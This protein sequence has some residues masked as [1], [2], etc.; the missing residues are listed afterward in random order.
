MKNNVKPKVS[1]IVPVY[2]VEKY[3]EKCLVS[4]I[5]QTYKN[6]EF[7][8][9]NDGSKDNSCKII[10]DIKSKISDNRIKIISQENAGVSAARNRGLEEST[11]EY[12]VFVDADDFLAK[13][14][15]E[16]MVTLILKYDSDFA[17]SIENFKKRGEEQESELFD[18]M[19]TSNESVALLL[20]LRVTVGCWNKIYKKKLLV[21]NDIKFFTDLFYGEGLSFI[22]RVSQAT[23][24]IAI[25]NK[26]VY[27]YRKNNENSATTKYDNKKFHN[28][29]KALI[30]IGKSIDLSNEQIKSSYFIHLATFYLG[31]MVKII[32]NKKTK[33]MKLDY[34][35]WK[36]S[37]RNNMIYI[38]K[39]RYISLYRKLMI[40]GGIFFPHIIAILDVRRN[41]KI[42]SSSV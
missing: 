39:S 10:N 24:K 1:V 41:K 36:K 37:L 23:S 20:G 34:K 2:N 6:C 12:I 11:G 26:K 9:V 42:F 31:A 35:K 22:I 7:I 40:F 29:E 14:F 21:D 18:K 28:G 4:L 15:V 19:I 30:K 5:N 16:Y 17:Y 13:D 8:F 38:F 32:E 27:Y 3:I 25:G 33:D